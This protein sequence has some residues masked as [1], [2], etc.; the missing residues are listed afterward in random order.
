MERDARCFACGK[1]LPPAAGAPIPGEPR[2]A[3]GAE[4]QAGRDRSSSSIAGAV[5]GAI[6]LLHTIPLVF[7][8]Q[9]APAGRVVLALA[10]VA[11]AATA[12]AGFL[13]KPGTAF[14]AAG[15]VVLRLFVV[16]GII[17]GAIGAV[18]L[19][20]LILLFIACATGGFKL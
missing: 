3:P 7:N 17:A 18:L 9:M 8:S 20:L 1:A 16:I 2:I 6:L 11:G 10:I 15:R 5:I 14:N 12:A 4:V 13:A 19:G